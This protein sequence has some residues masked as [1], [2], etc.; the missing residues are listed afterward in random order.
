MRTAP[1]LLPGTLC[2]DASPVRGDVEFDAMEPTSQPAERGSH[3]STLT[4]LF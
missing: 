4:E 3:D 2:L 1:M